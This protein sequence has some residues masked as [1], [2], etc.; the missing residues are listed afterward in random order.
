MKGDASGRIPDPS[1]GNQPRD[2]DRAARLLDVPSPACFPG[3]AAGE[4]PRPRQQPRFR[5]GGTSGPVVLATSLKLTPPRTS[6]S[7]CTGFGGDRV[8]R[9]EPLLLGVDKEYQI[10]YR[11]PASFP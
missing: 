10:S 2:E 11:P 9:G 6:C 1:L 4:L 7:R 5:P 8:H 3:R